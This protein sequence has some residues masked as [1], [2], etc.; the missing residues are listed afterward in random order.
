MVAL[1]MAGRCERSPD[2]D[3]RVSKQHVAG[4]SCRDRC[5][6]RRCVLSILVI[7]LIVIVIL[8]LLGFFGFRRRI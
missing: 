1:E 5:R 3:A 4:R 7:I 8:A 2:E 6:T